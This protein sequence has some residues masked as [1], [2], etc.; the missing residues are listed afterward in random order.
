[1]IIA[2]QRNLSAGFALT[3]RADYNRVLKKH[4]AKNAQKAQRR[5]FCTVFFK[6]FNNDNGI[7]R[8]KGGLCL[9]CKQDD[10]RRLFDVTNSQKGNV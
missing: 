9:F 4:T 3:Q 6:L 10:A 2:H 5:I 8:L 7:E 1:M